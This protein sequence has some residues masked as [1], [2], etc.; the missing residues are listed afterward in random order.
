MVTAGAGT[1][2]VWVTVLVFPSRTTV[3]PGRVTVE[4]GR[5]KVLAEP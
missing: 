2:K 5:M 4:P 3:A 1:A